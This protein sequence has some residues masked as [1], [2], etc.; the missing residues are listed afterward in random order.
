[1]SQ[2]SIGRGL[3]GGRDCCAKFNAFRA[4]VALS[5][6]MIVFAADVAGAM[7]VCHCDA[8]VANERLACAMRKAVTK[9]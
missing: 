6:A 3:L 4:P 2:H 9:V 7:R 8:G 1:M 5:P